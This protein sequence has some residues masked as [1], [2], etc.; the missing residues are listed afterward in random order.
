MNYKNVHM[1]FA[2]II[3]MVCLLTAFAGEEDD[4]FR[5]ASPPRHA[6]S[7]KSLLAAAPKTGS[8]LENRQRCNCI[9]EDSAAVE[10][11]KLALHGYLA[12]AGLSYTDTPLDEVITD[13]QQ[14]F[15]IPMRIDR[16]ALEEVGVNA[17]SPVTVELRDV[18]RQSALRLILKPL[19]LTYIIENEV[20]LITTP[21]K[22]D[23]ELLTCVYDVRDFGFSAAPAIPKGS[24]PPAD[25]NQLVAVIVACI[26]KDTWAEHGGG[27]AEIQSL[28]SDLL[29]ISQTRTVHEKIQ[30]LLNTIRKM[31]SSGET[32]ARTE[33]PSPAK[34]APAPAPTVGK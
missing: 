9:D 11:I 26:A 30:N 8:V 19:D 13:L 17:E 16:A 21:D 27:N 6:E 1:Y 32:A 12:G 22:A 5:A 4:P 10:K 31:K 29:V 33:I 20:L 18:S 2:V 14:R 23:K 7:E 15:A 25:N 24:S 3:A 28:G 34:L